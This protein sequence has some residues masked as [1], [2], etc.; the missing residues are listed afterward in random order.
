MTIVAQVNDVTRGPF[1]LNFYCTIIIVGKN[2]WQ[3][4]FKLNLK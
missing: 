4:N 2:D 3:F 1:G